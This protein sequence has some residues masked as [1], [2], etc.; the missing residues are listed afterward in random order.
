L[1]EVLQRKFGGMVK[2]YINGTWLD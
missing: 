1:D 2:A